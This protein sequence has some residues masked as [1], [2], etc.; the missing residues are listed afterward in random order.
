ME[1]TTKFKLC[2]FLN[3]VTPKAGA[4]LEHLFNKPASG[5]I[6]VEKNKVLVENKVA[7]IITLIKK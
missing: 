4:K 2:N 7:P 3:L 5:A 6:V 1:E